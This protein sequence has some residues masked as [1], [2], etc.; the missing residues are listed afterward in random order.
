MAKKKTAVVTVTGIPVYAGGIVPYFF[1]RTGVV[2]SANSSITINNPGPDAAGYSY[3]LDLLEYS[4]DGTCLAIFIGVTDTTGFTEQV[5]DSNT[6]S[7]SIT[8]TPDP[9]SGNTIDVSIPI[10]Y[11]NNGN[12]AECNGQFLSSRTRKAKKA[13]KPDTKKASQKK[14]KAQ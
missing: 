13:K 11:V 12:F 10:V 9:N 3:N 1:E 5:V 14:A 2:F 7:I 8:I 6:G 4:T